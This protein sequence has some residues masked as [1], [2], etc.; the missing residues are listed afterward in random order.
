M[1][2]QNTHKYVFQS[3]TDLFLNMR[4]FFYIVRAQ[5]EIR[6]WQIGTTVSH[7]HVCV[8]GESGSDHIISDLLIYLETKKKRH[9]PSTILYH[10]GLVE[11]NTF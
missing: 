9:T 2:S 8:T 10:L 6:L 3:I 4:I 11:Q 1:L 7:T 5:F